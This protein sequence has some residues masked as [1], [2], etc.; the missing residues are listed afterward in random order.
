[1]QGRIDLRRVGA[2]LACAALLVGVVVVGVPAPSRAAAPVQTTFTLEGCDRPVGLT[3]PQPDGS[4]VCRDADYG[5]G[6]QGSNWAELD[7]VPFRLTAR[8]KPAQTLTVV[9]AADARDGDDIGFDHLSEPTLNARLSGPACQQPVAGDQTTELGL[10]GIDVTLVRA[11]EVSSQGDETCVYDW[12]QRL[13][14]GSGSSD[15]SVKTSLLNEDL[16]TSGVGSKTVALNTEQVDAQ[17]ISKQ[18]QAASGDGYLWSVS[19]S[20]VAST[21]AVDTCVDNATASFVTTISWTRTPVTGDVTW[22]TQVFATNPSSRR[23]NVVVEDV[24]SADGA[25]VDRTTGPMAGVPALS[26]NVKVL[27]HSGTA[28]TGSVTVSDIATATYLDPH[29]GEPIPIT[30]T[31]TA[32]STVQLNRAGNPSAEISDVTTSSQPLAL[33]AFTDGSSDVSIGEVVDAPITWESGPVSRSGSA[34]LTFAS[35]LPQQYAGVVSVDDEASLTDALGDVVTA[36]ASASVVGQP[37]PPRLTLVKVVDVPPTRDSTFFFSLWPLG[38]GGAKATDEPM[39]DGRVTVPSGA[40]ASG[41]AE[42][43]LPP[44]EFGYLWEE[45]PA[46]GYVAPDAGVLAPMDVCESATG[47]V[48]NTRAVGTIE[49]TKAVLGPTVGASA[50]ATVLVDCGTDAAYDEILAVSPGIPAST[51][52]IP[53]GTS[54]TVSEPDPPPGYE[55]VAVSPSQVSVTE[56]PTP[57]GVTVTNQRLLGQ[58]TV[59]KV[60]DGVSA[61]ASTTF[62]AHVDCEPGDTYD[63]DV[64]LAVTPPATQQTSDPLAIPVGLRCTV[65]EPEIPT[66]WALAGIAP[67][68]VTIGTDPSAVAITNARAEGS[69]VVQKIAEGQALGAATSFPINVDCTDG[70]GDTVVLDVGDQGAAFEVIDGIPSGSV[71]TISEDAPTE[72]W[73]LVDITPN[74]VVIGTNRAAPAAVTVTNRRE[75]GRIDI[76]KRAVG[77]IAGATQN[78][79]VRVDC[80]GDGNDTDLTLRMPGDDGQTTA[81]VGGI[82]T[83]VECT[84]TEPDVPPGWAVTG[85]DPNPVLVTDTPAAVTITNTRSLGGLTIVKQLEGDVAGADTTFTMHASCPDAG[86]EQDVTLSVSNGAS[87]SGTIGGI[88]SGTTCTVTETDLA[89]GWR[90]G[91]IR[92]EEVRIPVYADA[93][94]A[95]SNVRETGGVGITKSLSGPISGAP[96]TFSAYLDCD[97][98]AYDQPVSLTLAPDVT[99][100]VL[101]DG[102]PTGTSCVFTEPSIPPQWTL[103]GIASNEI[104]IETTDIVEVNIVNVRATGELS[105]TKRI[106]GELDADATFDLALDCDDDLFDTAVPVTVPAGASSV[107][108]SFSGIPTGVTCAVTETRAATGWV[109]DS[110]DP[111]SVTVSG[112]PTTVVVSNRFDA[113]SP[114]LSPSP[115][116]LPTGSGALPSTGGGIPAAAIVGGVGLLLLGG[117]VLAMR[118]RRRRG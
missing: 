6:N 53:T 86:L 102:I 11:L 110:I 106:D 49:V 108:E 30:T 96:T 51:R 33:T 62:T 115:D 45:L 118:G 29:T 93:A 87:A 88:P 39:L 117:G 15:W 70:F 7:L 78:F 43:T 1:M 55:L 99:A 61:G 36:T 5:T 76:V 24:V 107:T 85:I 22:T 101:V 59:T 56:G 69:L 82:P 112:E 114:A 77:P 57:V 40:S 116:P 31:A 35:L 38:A 10:G 16:T 92:P 4:F 18:I 75:T 42:V 48:E 27:E 71:C 83:G 44:S 103:G 3:M 97:G 63:S 21:S 113:A 32:S 47:V 28:P 81:T 95:V 89:A 14:M 54:C 109:L 100:T 64:T 58:L 17:G 90:L 13:G 19:K 80:A 74:P 65:T 79:T 66:G 111:G 84:V 23:L 73:E 67:G 52:P 34:T 104:T 60:L 46:P 98:A 91:L 25:E 9:I 20:N 8:V 41:S 105:I 12:H 26:S 37:S 68:A 94:V 50:T 72:G 2:Y